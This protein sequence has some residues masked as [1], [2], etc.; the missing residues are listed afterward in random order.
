MLR[1]LVICCFCALFYWGL[2]LKNISFHIE[3][4]LTK[5]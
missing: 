2:K 1:M 3:Q 5:D 4:W